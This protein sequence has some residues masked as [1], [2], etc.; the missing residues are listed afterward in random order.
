MKKERKMKE[1]EF[2]LRKNDDGDGK[3]EWAAV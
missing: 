2:N 1:T 3:I